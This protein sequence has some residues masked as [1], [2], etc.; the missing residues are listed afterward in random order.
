M[1]ERSPPETDDVI[2]SDRNRNVTI[3]DCFRDK[4]MSC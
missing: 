2:V 1:F 4:Q 3:E